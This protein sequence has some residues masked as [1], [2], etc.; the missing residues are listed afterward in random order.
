[1]KI[2]TEGIDKVEAVTKPVRDKAG[3]KYETVASLKG[4][5]HLDRFGRDHALLLVKTDG[6]SYNLDT[7]ELP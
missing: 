5:E 3:L 4:V 7:I 6:G 2:P 1:M